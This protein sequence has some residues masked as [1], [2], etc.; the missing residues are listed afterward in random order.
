MAFNK[1][2]L[3]DVVSFDA[4]ED[5][6]IIFNVSGGALHK[7]ALVIITERN[8]PT[9]VYKQITVD[10]ESNYFILPANTLENNKYYAMTLQIGVE[11]DWS[12]KSQSEYFT[13]FAKPVISIKDIDP[14]GTST[15]TS[16]VHTFVGT[17]DQENDI[18]RY[19]RF[20]IYND[21]NTLF[22][23]SG[24]VYDKMI[25]IQVGGMRNENDYS[26]SLEVMSQSGISVQTPKIKFRVKF[27]KSGIQS[28]MDIVCDTYSGDVTV[29]AIAKDQ[30]GILYDY[31][32]GILYETKDLPVFVEHKDNDGDITK[33]VSLPSDKAVEFLTDDFFVDGFTMQLW[34]TRSNFTDML[35]I[36][37]I[38]CGK[39][40]V[41]IRCGATMIEALCSFNGIQTIY[42][43]PIEQ[44]TSPVNET[45]RI[46]IKNCAVTMDYLKGGAIA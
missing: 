33:W 18:I 8:K 6:K 28:Q 21:D 23:D 30:E 14:S 26:I 19:Y 42:G 43:L 11:G 37:K 38:I 31:R 39:E 36:A 16:S 25:A 44:L 45:L 13:C 27:A 22:Y 29:R 32:D 35:E 9:V 46:R 41:L 5:Q 10:A 34:F 2:M 17:Y 3:I 20:R 15:I 1:P 12:E 40:N 24:N 4:T 7:K